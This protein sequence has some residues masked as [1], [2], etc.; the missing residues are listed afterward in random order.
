VIK[1]NRNKTSKQIKDLQIDA[2]RFCYLVENIHDFNRQLWLTEVSSILPRIHAVIAVIDNNN[3]SE[4]L[5]TLSD[6]EERFEMFCNLKTVLGDKDGYEWGEELRDNEL[7]GSLSDDL[8]DL[9]FEIRRGL[10]L[11]KTG[12]E[13]S[14]PAALSLWRD[15]FFL[16][17]GKHLVDAQRHLYDLRVHHRI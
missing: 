15:G 9:Y 10:D 16:H 4:C 12:G 1:E 8:S 5:F 17:W 6:I 7:Y 2:E 11:I 3:R 14:V 13:G